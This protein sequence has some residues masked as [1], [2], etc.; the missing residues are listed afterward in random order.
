MKRKRRS[1]VKIGNR[2]HYY[3]QAI[4]TFFFYSIMILG[5]LSIVATSNI[6]TS[7]TDVA[8]FFQNFQGFYLLEK[9]G[10]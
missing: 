1:V 4:V 2:K 3:E 8:C 10:N 7:E 9:N 5:F 6:E